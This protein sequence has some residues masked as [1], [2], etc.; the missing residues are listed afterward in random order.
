MNLRRSRAYGRVIRAL[1]TPASL[2]VLTE[3][4][5]QLVRDAADTL[6]LAPAF[7]DGAGA[8]LADARTVLLNVP[9]DELAPFLE[10]LAHDLENAGPGPPH[11]LASANMDASGPWRPIRESPPRQP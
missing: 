8:G 1:D 10:Q 2:A 11:P 9:T 4:E 7:D 5:R 6:V 3:D